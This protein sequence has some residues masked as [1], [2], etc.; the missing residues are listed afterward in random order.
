MQAGYWSS[1]LAGFKG[2]T[3]EIEP[4]KKERNRDVDERLFAESAVFT[5]FLGL[6]L[7]LTLS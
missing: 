2:K 1:W 3:N 7:C 4:K 5:W 6:G